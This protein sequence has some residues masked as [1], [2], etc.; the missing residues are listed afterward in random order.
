MRI[1]N[2]TELREALDQAVERG[3][4][5]TR[6]SFEAGGIG[7]EQL[8]EILAGERQRLNLWRDQAEAMVLHEISAPPMPAGATVAVSQKPTGKLH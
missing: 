8:E 6:E 1:R 7:G 4:A 2:R 5:Q 3:L